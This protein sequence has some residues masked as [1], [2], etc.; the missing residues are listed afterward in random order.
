M[1]RRWGSIQRLLVYGINSKAFALRA[2]GRYE[3]AIKCFDKAL[4]EDPNN[5][6]AR[7]K[8][9]GEDYDGV[10]GRDVDCE[11]LEVMN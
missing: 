5:I 1:I 11:V 7:K 3:E 10:S 9:L 6:S 2:L 4:E 8:V